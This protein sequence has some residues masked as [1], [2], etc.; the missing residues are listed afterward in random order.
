MKELAALCTFYTRRIHLGGST[1]A[2]PH[3][4]SCGLWKGNTIIQ[5][6]LEVIIYR[7]PKGV[8]P[9]QCGKQN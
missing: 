6:G 2:L 7:P 8:T 9:A 1:A 5:F 3:T 4:G